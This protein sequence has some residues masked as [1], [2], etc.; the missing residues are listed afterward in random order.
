MNT[1]DTVSSYIK[2]RKKVSELI[3]EVLTKNI[4]VLQALKEY[5]KNLGDPTL[6]AA[7]HA[8]VHLEA[9]EDIRNSDANYRDEQDMYLE[10]I[11]NILAEGNA[12]PCN[13]IEEYNK[14]Y[15]DS[16]IYPNIDK[17]TVFMRLKKM[18]NL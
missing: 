10:D 13:V 12:L 7:F 6:N 8:L 5:P 4:S 14:Y 15:K 2:D 16:L 17:K 3:F 1:S 9:D 11:A 18:I